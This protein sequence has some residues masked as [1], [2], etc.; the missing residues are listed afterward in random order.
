MNATYKGISRVLVFT[1]VLNFLVCG[2]KIV[3]GMISKSASMVA[4]GLHSLTDG[5]SNIIGLVGIW[6]ASRPVDER[7]PYGHKKFETFTTIIIAA[8]LF[9]VCFEVLSSAVN[10]F[11]HPEIVPEISIYSFIVMAG[12]LFANIWISRY[13]TKRG[14]ELKSDF[15]VSDAKHTASDIYVSISVIVSLIVVRLGLPIIDIV[16]SVVIALII[17]RAAIEI[18]VH[19]ANILCD[20]APIKPDRVIEVVSKINGVIGCHKVRTRGR[21][22]DIKVDLH[23]WVDKD[24]SVEEGHNLSHTIEKKLRSDIS[25]VSE[26]IVHIEPYSLTEAVED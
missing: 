15:L 25:G 19:S 24:M 1:L 7:H 6:I 8:L 12:T 4:D 22:D 3:F 21:D 11:Q 5:T 2:A 13:E 9:V 14:R 23:I 16:T 26:V 10:R 18:V 17:A 20:A